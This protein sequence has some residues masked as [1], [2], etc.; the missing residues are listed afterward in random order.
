MRKFWKRFSQHSLGKFGLFFL[1]LFI[2]AIIFANYLTPYGPT[3]NDVINMNEPPSWSHPLGTDGLGRDMLARI[4]YGG[5]LSLFMGFS[6]AIAQAVIGTF[7]GVV[8]GVF[9]SY[10][11]ALVQR[12]V[13][14][15]LSVPRV[16]GAMILVS[17]LNPGAFSM[18]I[19]LTAFGWAAATRL[20]RGELLSIREKEYIKAADAI[21]VSTSRLIFQHYLPNVYPVIIVFITLNIAFNILATAVLSFLG[22]GVPPPTPTWGAMLQ[23]AQSLHVLESKPW[24]W[25]PPGIAIS[26]TVLSVNFVGDAIRDA[27]DPK[28]Y[29]KVMSE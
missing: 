13:E 18:I 7:F 9:G 1:L 27:L 23:A 10:L 11:D 21:G 28:Y 20:V 3:E 19:G 2:F 26:L 15:Q 4:L 12:L 25:L 5:R 22:L 17:I 6:I 8:S 24:I 14:I 29:S 16:I